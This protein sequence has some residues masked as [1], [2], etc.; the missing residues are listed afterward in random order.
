[1]RLADIEFGGG[2]TDLG[3][4]IIEPVEIYGIG[5]PGRCA[6]LRRGLRGGGRDVEPPEVEVEFDERLAC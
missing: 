4:D 6:A 1:M 3:V 5:A 2:Q